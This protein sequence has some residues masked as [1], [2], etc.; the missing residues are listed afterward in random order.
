MRSS[1]IWILL[2]MYVGK[3]E[4]SKAGNCG[5]V[6]CSLPQYIGRPSP[7]AI[8][9]TDPCTAAACCTAV[10]CSNSPS[11][12]LAAGFATTVA[13]TTGCDAVAEPACATVCLAGYEKT[14]AN[15]PSI[16]CTAADTWSL[17]DPCQPISCG[18]FTLAA[19]NNVQQPTDVTS[20]DTVPE[21]Q[22]CT[23]TCLAGYQTA[24]GGVATTVSCTGVGA[25]VVAPGPCTEI[26]CLG[27]TLPTGFMT[28]A[29]A[30]ACPLT[31]GNVAAAVLTAATNTACSL[32]CLAGYS[33]AGVK[34]LSCSPTQLQPAT[35]LTCTEVNCNQYPLLAG[36]AAGTC[37]VTNGNVAA[38][39][40]KAV[41]TTTCNLA[42]GLGYTQTGGT[43]VALTC[44]PT[45]L[46]PQT[47]LTCDANVCVGALTP[48]TRTTLGAA[49]TV[50]QMVCCFVTLFNL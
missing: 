33:A 11:V 37:T 3:F 47:T 22:S 15:E 50:A 28:S 25:Y 45:Q 38:G 2:L 44:S 34:T 23:L 29:L 9:C 48:P 19:A 30:D 12:V 20:C 41:T 24:G 5:S 17:S 27:Y 8:Q 13:D 49:L 4:I 32:E 40:L 42:C 26:S 14:T 35:T 1:H 18:A 36:M 10:T 39:V 16:S 46:T 7:A 6:V 31:G 43:A 21:T